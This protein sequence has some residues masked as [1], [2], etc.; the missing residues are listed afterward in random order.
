MRY[1]RLWGI[2]HIWQIVLKHY[3]SHLTLIFQKGE[4]LPGTWRQEFTVLRALRTWPALSNMSR[5]SPC[6]SISQ[7]SHEIG[8]VTTSFTAWLLALL[9]APHACFLMHSRQRPLAEPRD[10]TRPA[11]S[12]LK[13]GHK[14]FKLEKKKRVNDNRELSPACTLPVPMLHCYSLTHTHTSI[15]YH[16]RNPQLLSESTVRLMYLRV[17]DSRDRS[18]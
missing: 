3:Y 17:Y 12:T 10:L 9:L 6:A 7:F 16:N 13:E 14:Q 1:T 2:K 11:I 18:H 15:G 5:T 4:R 8:Q